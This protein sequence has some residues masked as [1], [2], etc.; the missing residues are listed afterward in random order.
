MAAHSSCFS[1][2][3]LR[4]LSTVVVFACLPFVVPGHPN[5]RRHLA[6]P[7]S[8]LR[9]QKVRHANAVHNLYTTPYHRPILCSIVG[10]IVVWL[11]GGLSLVGIWH[12]LFSPFSSNFHPFS[13]MFTLFRYFLP[14][15]GGYWMMM[16]G[17]HPTTSTFLAQQRLAFFWATS[18][19]LGTANI[20]RSTSNIANPSRPHHGCGL[21]CT[22]AIS[23]LKRSNL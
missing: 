13:S 21:L 8:C 17:I 11:V 1:R 2:Q 14:F 20:E 16:M 5:T 6:S 7:S 4:S 9:G 22:S 10:I 18:E 3:M 19:K 15:V 12:S 23:S